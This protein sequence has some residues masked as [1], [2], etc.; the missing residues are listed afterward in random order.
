MNEGLKAQLSTW[1]NN[2]TELFPSNL[3]LEEHTFL[4]KKNLPS[5]FETISINLIL[6]AQEKPNLTLWDNFN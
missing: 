2:L 5:H 3:I 1:L 6:P 4:G